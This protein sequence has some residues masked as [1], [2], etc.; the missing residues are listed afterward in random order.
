M[1]DTWPVA[2]HLGQR[3]KI[4]LYQRCRGAK[5]MLLNLLVLIVTHALFRIM[6]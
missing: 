2:I 6:F 5:L 4:H 3:R 1:R